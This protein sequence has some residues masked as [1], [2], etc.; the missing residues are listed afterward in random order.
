M[1]HEKKKK[2]EQNK[3]VDIQV[4]E[5]ATRDQN[6]VNDGKD[7][8]ASLSEVV[9]NSNGDEKTSNFEFANT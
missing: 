7:E 1:E 8:H 3:N 6:L 2:Q 5:K 4:R 9:V